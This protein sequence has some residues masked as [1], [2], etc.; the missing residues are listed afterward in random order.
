[1]SG[2]YEQIEVP[3][4]ENGEVKRPGVSLYGGL[5][6]E[7]DD[8]NREGNSVTIE[9]EPVTYNVDRSLLRFQPTVRKRQDVKKK[10]KKGFAPVVRPIQS[11][12]V[13][14][15]ESASPPVATQ[16]AGEAGSYWD[17]DYDPARP[18]VYKEYIHSEEKLAEEED[19]E[20]YLAQWELGSD[21]N[22]AKPIEFTKSTESEDKSESIEETSFHSKPEP[23]SD[24]KGIGSKLLQ[25][26][27]WKPGKGLGASEDGIV[28]PLRFSTHNKRP[29][30]G[31]I[32][33]KNKNSRQK[34]TS[35]ASP[36]VIFPN[37]LITPPYSSHSIEEIPSIF[38]S[39]CQSNYGPV[40]R[41]AT[42]HPNIYVK[43]QNDLSA[44][45]AV[46][47]SQTSAQ[48]YNE[49]AFEQGIF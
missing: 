18:N 24:K 26:Y 37:L 2:L 15:E 49:E 35:T 13:D 21:A 41:V 23:V 46:N 33:D 6:D 25:K 20:D 3:E 44:L 19:W 42:N 22:S 29:G 11:N 27:G 30:S 34:K 31:R 1:M 14:I 36:V 45:R 40:T 10:S 17:E 28:N 7:E 8:V 16:W 43:F 48:Y 39:Y 5:E 4:R 38:G 12:R 32:V 47:N 9:K